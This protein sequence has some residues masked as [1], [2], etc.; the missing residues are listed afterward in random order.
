MPNA[1]GHPVTIR[2]PAAMAP[3][4]AAKVKIR[5]LMGFGSD[6]R[7]RIDSTKTKMNGPDVQDQ[8]ID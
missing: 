1:S 3:D 4:R 2:C 6:Q 8:N 7:N 5:G